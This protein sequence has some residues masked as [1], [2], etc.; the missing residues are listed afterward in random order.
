MRLLIIRHGQT[1]SNVLGALDTAF[2]GPGLTRLGS[3]Q[4]RAVPEA[5]AHE[6]VA[7]VYASPLVRTQLT[8]GPLA[9]ALD[10]GLRVQPGLEE[11]CA[12]ALEMRSDAEAAEAYASC[13]IA[14]MHGELDRPM[15]D[16]P[17]G[18]DFAARYD[19]AI[20]EIAAAHSARDTV[21]VFSHGAAIR[22][23]AA[24][25]SGIDGADAAELTIMNTGMCV[26]EG[27]PDSGWKL[28]D[29]RSEPLGGRGLEDLAARDVTG[30]SAEDAAREDAAR[31]DAAREDA[32]R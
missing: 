5:L 16:G 32:G 20:A 6:R 30:E 26:M 10:L 14:W 18:H 3:A 7:G 23:Y 19:A 15:P 2:P 17:N 8:A 21:A 29:W 22:V 13:L 1:P 25:R 12:G 4:A 11:I 31:E 9:D 28:D 27:D 24:L